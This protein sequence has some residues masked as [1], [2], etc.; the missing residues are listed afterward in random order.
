MAPKLW[1]AAGWLGGLEFRGILIRSRQRRKVV[2]ITHNSRR[3]EG[4]GSQGFGA[5]SLGFGAWG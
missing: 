2:I 5:S 3:M 4:I 1:A